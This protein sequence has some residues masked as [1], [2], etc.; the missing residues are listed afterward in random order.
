MKARSYSY[1]LHFQSS[2]IQNHDTFCIAEHWRVSHTYCILKIWLRKGD[3]IERRQ[4]VHTVP[5]NFY[6]SKPTIPTEHILQN[7]GGQLVR[8]EN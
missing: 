2:I 8:S 1:I 3:S 7:D 5:P 6:N 4:F